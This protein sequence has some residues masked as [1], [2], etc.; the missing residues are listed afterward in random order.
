[1]RRHNDPLNPQMISDETAPPQK[2]TSVGLVIGA[3][4]VILIVL[5]LL[6]FWY[7]R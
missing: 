7:T 3:A 1:M 2:P 4:V 6:V 5:G